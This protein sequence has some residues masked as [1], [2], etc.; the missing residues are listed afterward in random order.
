MR[1]DDAATLAR[2]VRAMHVAA[3]ARIL[4]KLARALGKGID[5]PDW[6]ERKLLSERELIKE[7]DW[8]LDGLK[9]SLP[10]AVETAVALAYNRGVAHAAGEADRLGVDDAF[11]HATSTG[12]E[13]ALARAAM[14]P[15]GGMAFQIRRWVDDTYSKVIQQASSQVLTGVHTRR[16]AAGHALTKLAEKGITGFVDRSGRRWDTV[17]YAEMAVRTTASQAMIQGHT[18][19]LQGLGI[20]TVSVSDAPEECKQCRP[21]EGRVLSLSGEG[22]GTR[23]SDGKTI[24]ASLAEAKSK[25]LFHPGC[26]HSTNMYLPGISTVPKDTAD[27]EGDQ[28]R[29]RQR[30]YERRVRELKRDKIIADEL[31]GKGTPQSVTVNRKL[32]GTYSEFKAF[33]DD[34]DRKNLT[35]RTSLKVR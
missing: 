18:D 14:E 9:D 2:D 34:N 22:V 32:Q 26:R 20:D 17:S 24:V 19:R 7:L 27:P 21:F 35:Y 31:Y 13:A 4:E 15:V 25:G 33:R 23:L 1:P 10:G 11:K 28:L 12:A 16:E 8:V 3:E 30:A 6:L 5:T 29:R